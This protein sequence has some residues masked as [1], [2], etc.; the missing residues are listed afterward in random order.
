[1]DWWGGLL[2]VLGWGLDMCYTS[3]GYEYR[4]EWMVLLHAG[5][6]KEGMNCRMG[7]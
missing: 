2:G 4:V 6:V 3:V 5:V 1:M 7:F